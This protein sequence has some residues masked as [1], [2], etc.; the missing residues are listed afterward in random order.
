MKRKIGLIIV[1]ILIIGCLCLLI[2]KDKLIP[3]KNN[4]EKEVKIVDTIDGFN[5]KLSENATGL[6]KTEFKKLKEILE[7]DVIDYENYAKSL[8]KLF[9]IDLYTLENKINKYDIT[10]TQFVYPSIVE[11]YIL[12]VEDTIY[13]YIED[14]SDSNRSQTLPKVSDVIID[15]IEKSS[16]KFDNI[17]YEAYKVILHWNYVED[18]E[19]DKE[20]TLYLVKNDKYL[21]VIEKNEDYNIDNKI[22]NAN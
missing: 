15:E 16:Y 8:S 19:Y 6:Y 10:S 14:N 21:Y 2:F 5:Y 12:N 17:N 3:K 22:D 20:G 18:L 9:I 7:N 13:K 11:N 4:N 1:L